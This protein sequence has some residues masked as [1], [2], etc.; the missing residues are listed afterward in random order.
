MTIA[1][2][3]DLEIVQKSTWC[4]RACSRALTASIGWSDTLIRNQIVEDVLLKTQDF[5]VGM[6]FK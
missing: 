1:N 4:S 3:K 5:K 2:K 6:Y